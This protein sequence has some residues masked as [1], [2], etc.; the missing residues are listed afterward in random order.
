MTKEFREMFTE[1]GFHRLLDASGSGGSLADKYPFYPLLSAGMPKPGPNFKRQAFNMVGDSLDGYLPEDFLERKTLDRRRTEK[2]VREDRTHYFMSYLYYRALYDDNFSIAVE[3]KGQLR[4]VTFV[5]GHLWGFEADGPRKA[6]VMV[7]GKGPGRDEAEEKR[8][9][10]GPTSVYFREVLE[11]MGIHDYLDWYVTNVARFPN[12]NPASDTTPAAWVNDCLPLL[13]QELR[14]VRPDYILLLGS[15]AISTILGEGQKF[16]NTNGKTHRYEIPIHGPGEAPAVHVAQVVTCVHPAAVSRDPKHEDDLI[17]TIRYFRDI[18]SGEAATTLDPESLREHLV[19]HDAESLAQLARRMEEEGRTE[20][21]IDTEFDGDTPKTGKVVMVQFSWEEKKAAAVELRDEKGNET[22]QG[23]TEAAIKIMSDI[24]KGRKKRIIGHYFNAD[25]WWLKSL[26]MGF[27][28]DQFYTSIDD[29]DPDGVER[30]F[31]WQKTAWEGGFDTMLAA[32]A[33]EE[34]ADFGLKE[35]SLRHTSIPNYE[36][37]LENWKKDEAK[38]L[39]CGVREL[40][41]FGACPRHILRPYGCYD[42]DATFR[43][44]RLYNR[45][46]G[47]LDKD[48]FGNCCRIPFWISMRACLAF[49]EMRE[50]GMIID[51]QRAEDLMVIF[52]EAL[53]RLK[54]ELR[55]PRNPDDPKSVG[56]NWKDFNPDST[57]Q[58]KEFMFGESYNGKY[59][60]KTGA[61]ISVRPE[62]AKTLNLIPYKSTGKRPK[63]WDT[64]RAQGKEADFTPAVD[65]ETLT[66]YADLDPAIGRL[67]DIRYIGQILKTVL[68]PPTEVEGEPVLDED[69]NKIYTRG[70]LSFIQ[71]GGTVHTNFSQTKETGRV[72]SWLP[73]LQNISKKREPDYQRILGR[74]Y[75]HSLRSIF[76]APPGWVFISADYTGA[77]LLGMA[78]E[79]GDLDMIAHCDRANLPDTGY[80]LEGIPCSHGARCD[81]CKYPHPDYYDIHANVAIRAFR[82]NDPATGQPLLSGRLAR[83]ELKRAKLGHYRDAAKPVDFGYAYGMTGEAAYRKAVEQGAKIERSDADVLIAGLEAQY[84]RLPPYYA[85]AAEC[86]HDPM[87]MMNCHGRYRRTYPTS[88]RK[89]QGD[90]ERQFKNF[91][92]QSLVADSVSLA[93]ANLVDY[94]REHNLH[95]RLALQL[96]D[97]IMAVV[98]VEEAETYYDNAIPTCMTDLVD[99]WPTDFRGNLRDDPRAPYHLKPGRSV[100]LRWGEP[101]TMEQA[102]KHGVPE[103][104]VGIGD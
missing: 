38:R 55:E 30:F 88:D 91:P 14:L 8:N 85:G 45:E 47:L 60:K 41:G 81:K 98:P 39:G 3:F 50:Q 90:V 16:K 96:H 2:K 26:G 103:R 64:I 21:A 104:F 24:F 23:G 6:R 46:N 53:N 97:D 36:I 100:Y 49:Y 58:C 31:G 1:E 22:F 67:R 40:P 95:F 101:I 11:R 54:K 52:R 61:S 34:T 79:A 74:L 37:D 70:L 80:S 93:M 66:V 83:S 9:F 19:F 27:L 102:R 18:L 4:A 92:I 76:V 86:S 33:H 13:H 65:K 51:L 12:F 78:I 73:P 57:V 99:I 5:P 10:V 7:I 44:Y 63:L 59:D 84:P 89:V 77:E 68:K 62:G 32:H 75:Q 20:F 94:R 71:P 42:A 87:W 15:E 25:L 17:K 69:G 28:E 29:P 82:P 43:L 72:S 56:L 48:R 35:L